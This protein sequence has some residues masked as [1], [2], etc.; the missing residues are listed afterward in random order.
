MIWIEQTALGWGLHRPAQ[1]VLR[2]DEAEFQ[3]FAHLV[4][5]GRDFSEVLL[6]EELALTWVA[7]GGRDLA[8]VWS[9]WR[10]TE[11]SVLGIGHGLDLAGL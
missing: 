9:K 1:F 7:R 3:E 10:G 8:V 11:C 6:G 4:P 2:R 5:L